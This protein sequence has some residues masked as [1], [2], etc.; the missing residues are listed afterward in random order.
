MQAGAHLGVRPDRV[1]VAQGNPAHA[2]SGAEILEDH[3]HHVFGA[4]VGAD[5]VKGQNL[6]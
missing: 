1:E 4:C 5:R 3:L 2:V 6:R